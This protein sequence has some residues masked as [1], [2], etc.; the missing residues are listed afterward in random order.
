MLGLTFL[1]ARKAGAVIHTHSKAAV[2]ATL[3]YPGKEFKVTHLEMIKVCW[4]IKCFRCL[5]NENG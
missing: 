4:E 3:L 5:A 2:M 1:T